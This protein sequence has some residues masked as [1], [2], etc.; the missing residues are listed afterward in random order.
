MSRGPGRHIADALARRGLA[1]PARLFLDAHRPLAPL[2]ADAG[3]ALAPLMRVAGGRVLEGLARL[4]EE[5]DGITR[6]MAELRRAEER[7]AEPR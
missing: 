3:A 5:E 2:V 4:V 1:E 6:L 7:H